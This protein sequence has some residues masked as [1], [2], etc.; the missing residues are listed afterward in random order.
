MNVLALDTATG[1]DACAA[2]RVGAL[3][4]HRPGAVL[5]LP[6]GGTPRGLYA[7]LVRRVHAG[8]LSL[9]QARLFNLD[10]FVGVAGDDPLGY[11]HYLR[12]HLVDPAQLPSAHCRFLRGDAPDL[13]AECRDYD[14]ALAAA[15]GID[16]AI[17]GLGANGHVA[18]NE[19]GTPWE[20]RTH[21]AALTPETL[22]AQDRT[23]LGG[24]AL[25]DRGLTM[26][27]ATLRAARAVLLLVAG[28]AKRDALAALTR[29]RPDPRWPVTSLLGHPDLT[30]LA[31]A[32]LSAAA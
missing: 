32:D 13:A 24:R 30:V 29:G 14:A 17:L 26:G 5:A 11:A 1:F 28:T 18:F 4:A 12:R 22:R 27:I 31:A 9:R 7:E 19:P 10:E 2:D 25:P 8:R 21:V 3:L 23:T 6:T 15:G 20:T 16:L